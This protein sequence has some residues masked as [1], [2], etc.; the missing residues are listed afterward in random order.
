VLT[1]SQH[2][3]AV[4]PLPTWAR[5]PAEEPP[6]STRRGVLTRAATAAVVAG[7]MVALGHRTAAMVLVAV[8][9]AVSVVSWL[10]PAVARAIERF[11]LR[12]QH[13]AGRVLTVVLLT[14]VYLVVFVPAA[15]VLRLLRRDPLALGSRTGDASFWR[16]A[17][18]PKRPLHRR[19]YTDERHPRAAGGAVRWRPL[20]TAL[21]V[22]GAVVLLAAVDLGAGLAMGPEPQGQVDEP[23]RQVDQAA[24]EV[25]DVGAGADEPWAADLYAELATAYER[26]AYHP[27]RGWTVPDFRGTHVNVNDEVRRSYQTSLPGPAVEVFFFGGS[28]MMGWFQRDEHT[29]PSE[30]VRLAEADGIAVKA[31]NYGQPAYQN[32]QEVMLLQELV[33]G[34]AVPDVAVFY[35]GVNELAS[36]FRSGPSEDPIHLQSRTIGERLAGAAAATADDEEPEPASERLVDAYLEISAIGRAYR[37]SPVKQ[38]AERVTGTADTEHPW[39]DQQERPQERGRAASSLHGRG[40]AL[41]EALSSGYEFETRWFWQPFIYTKDAAAGEEDV[42]GS[43]GTDPAAWTAA[44]DEARAQLAEPVVDLS[45][46]LDGVAQPVFYD[47]VHTNEAGARA[48]AR[49]MY[50]RLKPTLLELQAEA[51]P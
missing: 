40:V 50:E 30:V 26:S 31:L 33:S 29:I 17:A 5:P 46:A 18:R 8:F 45:D 47:F 42:V 27:F 3:D 22:V 48:V 11:L 9:T 6:S 36:Q 20:R 35:D 44:S 15:L 51:A 12:F 24:M 7:V 23:V 38:L 39:P 34:G 4:A 32:W 21:A 19:T 16:P 28:T 25:P 41:G 13:L 37:A 49:A 1:T 14:A 43:W 2:D 10:V